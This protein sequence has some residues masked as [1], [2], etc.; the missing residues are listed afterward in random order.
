MVFLAFFFVIMQVLHN[1]NFKKYFE[2]DLST[3][4]MNRDFPDGPVT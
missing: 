1:S 3:K 2:R 4:K